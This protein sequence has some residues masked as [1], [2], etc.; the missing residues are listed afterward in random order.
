MKNFYTLLASLFFVANVG[1][2]QTNLTEAVDFTVTTVHGDEINLFDLLDNGQHV[3]IDFFFTTCPPCIASVPTVNDAYEKYG[4]NNGDVFFLSVDSGDSDAQVLQYEE[5]HGGLIPSV[6]GNDGGGNAVVSAYGI[7]AFPTIILIAP[8]RSIVSQDI[9]P[10]TE[11]NFH[12]AI[13]TD[14]GLPS[15]EAAC[16]LVGLNDLVNTGTAIIKSYPNPVSTSLNLEF[17]IATATSIT[18]EV[19]NL[20]GQ[21]VMTIPAEQYA[22]GI[23]QLQLSTEELSNGTYTVNLVEPEGMVA[24][25]KISVVK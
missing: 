6:S 21:K 1:F 2:S 3:V 18:V 11:A 13:T 24:V 12:A 16:S 10:V 20:V 14:A 19:Y 15:N 25:T 8:D 5:D 9:F 4:C 17:S 22:A 7:G 23:H